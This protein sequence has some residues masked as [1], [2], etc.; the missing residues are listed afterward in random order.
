MTSTG[1]DRVG[2]GE[3]PAPRAPNP[4]SPQILRSIRVAWAAADIEHAGHQWIASRELALAPGQW[5]AEIANER[6]GYSRR[7]PEL[8]FWPAWDRRRRAAV[9]LAPALSNP[10][11]E[12]AALEGWQRS[13]SAGQYAQVRYVAGPAFVSHLRRVAEDIGLTAPQLIV[14]ERVMADEFPVL[15]SVSE[16]VAEE[17]VA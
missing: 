17:S 7:L 4:F 16:E 8:V 15:A 6:G 14:G 10:R 1:L 3:L 11:R 13:I 5:S 12:R 9:V 2:L